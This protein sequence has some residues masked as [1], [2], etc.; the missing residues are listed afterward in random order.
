MSTNS[1]DNLTDTKSPQGRLTYLMKIAST[2][3]AI[4]RI[5]HPKS[6]H[7][8]LTRQERT[9]RLSGFPP[10]KS[11]KTVSSSD[12]LNARRRQGR[13]FSLWRGSWLVRAIRVERAAQGDGGGAILLQY[14]KRGV[15]AA[16]HV[17][18][19]AR[20]SVSTYLVR[21]CW[22]VYTIH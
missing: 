16:D 6:S 15:K 17:L 19:M 4:T 10:V 20:E 9:E 8:S 3:H 7:R 18:K 11:E 1:V 22:R 12:R 2:F 13:F 14:T 5:M 21:R